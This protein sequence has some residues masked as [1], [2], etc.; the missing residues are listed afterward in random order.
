MADVVNA[1]NR[2]NLKFTETMTVEQFKQAVSVDTIHVKRNPH[3]GKLFFTYGGRTG[4]VASKGIPSKPMISLVTDGKSS[5]ALLHEEAQSA[6]D[7][8]TF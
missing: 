1:E 6:P 7:V 4:A 8:A 5:F 3:T 2:G